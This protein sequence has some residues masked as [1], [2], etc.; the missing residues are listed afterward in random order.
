MAQRAVVKLHWRCNFH[1]ATTHTNIAE[2]SLRCCLTTFFNGSGE[3]WRRKESSYVNG[4]DRNRARAKSS[5]A[6]SWI[7]FYRAFRRHF[8]RSVLSRTSLFPA[9]FP[10][11]LCH[12]EGPYYFPVTA[13]WDCVCLSYCYYYFHIIIFSRQCFAFRDEF[14]N[15]VLHVMRISSRIILSRWRSLKH[16]A[17]KGKTWRWNIC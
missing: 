1:P 6:P 7:D 10:R 15:K 13:C 8:A 14:Q 4:W 17:N 12:L 3:S 5:R 16:F 9:V 11:A 2:I